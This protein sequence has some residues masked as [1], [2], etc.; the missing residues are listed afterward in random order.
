MH[1]GGKLDRRRGQVNALGGLIYLQDSSTSQ[2]Y[3]VDTG[4]AVSVLPHCSKAPPSGPPLSGADGRRISSWGTVSKKL[5]FGFKTF[6]CSFILAAVAKPILGVD[7]LAHHLLVDPFSQQVLDAQTLK[8]ICSS[9]ASA[10]SGRSR[11]TASLCHVSPAVRSLL[12]SFPAIVGDGSGTP[13]PKHG[14][15]HSIDMSGRPIFAKARRLDPE[16]LRPAESEFRALEKA[17]IVRR[18]NSL[19]SS[20]LH[21][22]PKP[23]GSWRPCG[24]YR[25]LNLAMTHDQYP[26][27]SIL[28]LSS[29][30]HGCRYFSV[31]DLVKGYHQVPMAPEDI[32]KTA[33]ITPFGLFEYLFMPFGLMNAAQTFQRLMDRLFGHFPFLFTYLDDHLIASRTLEEHMDHLS[34][35]F[36]VLQDNGLTINPGKCTFAVT[37]VKFLGHMV[38]ETGL[39]PLPRHVAAVENFPPPQDLKQLQRFLG[40]INFYR[41]F[42]PSVAQ[43]LKPLTDLLSGNPKT[44]TWSPAADVAFK[45]AKAALVAA[46]PLSH[47]APNATLALAV[48]ASDSHV[49]GVL[50]RPRMAAVGL[51]FE[52]ALAYTT[53]VFD[54]RPRTPGSFFGGQTFSLSPGRAPFPSPNR[55]QTVG[56]CY[57]SRYSSLVRTTT[58]ADG[59]PVRVHL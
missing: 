11:F 18:S 1:V 3:L 48:D 56:G 5:T 52:K 53:A 17:G 29:K 10:A 16:K 35:F 19:W 55:S 34:Q 57:V 33:I 39:I 46:V 58:A 7:F 43:T 24:D 47:P 40:L 25:R 37:S 31:I 8:P 45:A 59:V 28:D 6:L 27:L 2:R 51:L 32:Q 44:L 4:A 26:L 49:G 50:Q 20:P 42:L 23:D 54:F 36:S 14:I 22:V 13:R 38:S 30:L 9:A 12:A 15:E 41:R 21:M